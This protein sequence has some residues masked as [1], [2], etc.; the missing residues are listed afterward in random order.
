MSQHPILDYF[1]PTR[2]NIFK[3]KLCSKEYNSEI[4]GLKKH[5][6]RKHYQ[7]WDQIKSP[8]RQSF[9]IRQQSSQVVEQPIQNTIDKVKTNYKLNFEDAVFNFNTREISAK[10][11]I[12]EM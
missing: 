9:T 1:S 2:Q 7:I 5:F 8:V 4:D 3:C 12:L 11:I 6:S 10:K